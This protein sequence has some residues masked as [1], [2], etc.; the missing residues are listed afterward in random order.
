MLADAMED[1]LVEVSHPLDGCVHSVLVLNMNRTE[2]GYSLVFGM[3][4]QTCW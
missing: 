2:Q 4:S 1:S 3:C